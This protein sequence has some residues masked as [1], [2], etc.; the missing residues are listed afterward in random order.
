MELAPKTLPR[1]LETLSEED[2]H[3]VKRFLLKSGS[4]KDVAAQYDISYPTI[5]L[6]LDRLIEK[7]HLADDPRNADPFRL[8]VQTLA[9]DGQVASSTAK[10]LIR[11]YETQLKRKTNDE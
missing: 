11:A 1:W 9:A 10:A 2:L 6:R 8:M 4:L 3:F 7:I 5:R